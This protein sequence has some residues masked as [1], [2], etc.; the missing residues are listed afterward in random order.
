MKMG[1]PRRKPMSFAAKRRAIALFG[2]CVGLSL[3]GPQAAHAPPP[4]V[5]ALAPVET[6]LDSGQELVGVA[7]AEHGTIYVADRAAGL[8]YR[9]V[10]PNPPTVA[11]S[12]LDHPAGLALDDSGR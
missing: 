3:L 1:I 4:S 11:V 12:G 5:S 10:P 7:V 9:L 8:V 6:L 2:L